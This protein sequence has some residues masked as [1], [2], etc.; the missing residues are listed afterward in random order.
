MRPTELGVKIPAG[1]TP[2]P[3]TT[4]VGNKGDSTCFTMPSC[5]FTFGSVKRFPHYGQEYQ[6]T[7]YRLG[8]GI[9]S[10]TNY[11]I[12]SSKIKSTH[13]YR[14]HSHAKGKIEDGYYISG[15]LL[16]YEGTFIPKYKLRKTKQKK[17]PSPGQYSPDRMN[18][19]ELVSSPTTTNL[20]PLNRKSWI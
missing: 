15:N 9:H 7:G 11:N 10:P 17:S 2:S 20:S 14:Q 8:P 3:R 1:R 6:K 19:W 12:G 5:G 13:V 16:V 18:N 4:V